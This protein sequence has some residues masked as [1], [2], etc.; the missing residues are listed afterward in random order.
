[1]PRYMLDTN[2][3]IYLM[4]NQPEAVRKRFATCFVGDVNAKDFQHYPGVRIENWVDALP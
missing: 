2:T 3:C 1:M 4:K